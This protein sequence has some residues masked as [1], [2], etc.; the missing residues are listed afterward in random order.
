MHIYTHIYIQAYISLVEVAFE[1]WKFT[2]SVHKPE[3]LHYIY[4]N[5]VSQNVSVSNESLHHI[6]LY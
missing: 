3:S 5:Y 6:H 1:S 2:K 4:T